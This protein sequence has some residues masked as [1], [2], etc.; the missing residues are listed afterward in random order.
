MRVPKPMAKAM[1]AS[2]RGSLAGLVSLVSEQRLALGRA[3]GTG[4]IQYVPQDRNA[5]PSHRN[6]QHQQVD[7][8]SANLLWRDESFIPTDSRPLTK[9]LSC[10][11]AVALLL[12]QNP[13]KIQI[14]IRY[15]QRD[16]AWTSDAGHHPLQPHHL[17]DAP[18]DCVG[19]MQESVCDSNA[20]SALRLPPAALRLIS[21]KKSLSA[22]IPRIIG[23]RMSLQA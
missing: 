18:T 17:L 21:L 6:A 5:N 12:Y 23:R 9:S 14:F 22:T 1:M 10:K 8:G 19:F 11:C 15:R 4:S 16:D 20:K 3:G 2:S 7:V 13:Y